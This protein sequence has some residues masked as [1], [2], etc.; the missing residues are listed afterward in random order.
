MPGPGPRSGR[1]SHDERAEAGETVLPAGGQWSRAL[2][3]GDDG[4]R[5]AFAHALLARLAATYAPE[6]MVIALCVSPSRRLSWAWTRWLPHTRRPQD[7]PDLPG[8][9]S[10]DELRDSLDAEFSARPDFDPGA[11]PHHGEP[12]VIVIMDGPEFPAGDPLGGTGLRK[13]VVLDFSGTRRRPGRTTLRLDASTDGVRAVWLGRGRAERSALVTDDMAAAL[14]TPYA[15]DAGASPTGPIAELPDA[16][17]AGRRTDENDWPPPLTAAPRLDDLL[18]PLIPTR[19]RGLTTAGPPAGGPLTVPV[20]IV[21]RPFERFPGVLRVDL[22]GDEGHLFIAGGSGSGK[23]TLMITL[24]AALA[25][26]HTADEVQIH[27]LDLRGSLAAPA[28]LPH[29]RT[30]TDESDPERVGRTLAELVVLLD[31][32]RRLFADQGVDGMADYRRRRAD[33]EF[34][35]ERHGDVY[36]FMDDVSADRHELS[37]HVAALDRLATHGLAYG[38]HL[39]VAV[40]RWPE[41]P[42]SIGDQAATLLELRL[43]DP[44]ES[45]SDPRAAGR[46]P[47]RPGRGLASGTHFLT[48]LPRIDGVEDTRDLT[49]AVSELVTAVA[50]RWSEHPGASN[51]PALEGA[52]SAA[53]LPAAPDPLQAMLGLAESEQTP[54]MHDFATDPHLIVVGDEGSGKTNALRLIVRSITASHS[55]VKARFLVMDRRDDLVYAV[56][57]E[58]VLG[59]AV[60]AAVLSELVDGAARAIGERVPDPESR[61]APAPWLGPRLFIVVDDYE[62]VDEMTPSPFEPLFEYLTVG[63]EVGMHLVVARSSA[64]TGTA[65]TDPLLCALHEAGAATLALS[66][67]PAES[68][69]LDDIEPSVL[70]PGRGQY[71]MGGETTLIR[72]AVDD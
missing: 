10:V 61:E 11:P 59:H 28:D 47:R 35:E 55:P 4:P 6:E 49:V 16:L 12:L 36:L 5:R 14:L 7:E 19:D 56:P 9:S 30:V 48:A 25:L 2:F 39:V 45:A 32:R 27:C 43:G 60:S 21:D 58:F 62:Q 51:A 69:V 53:S 23:S 33:G 40:P 18:P 20:G 65:M 22:S 46:V 26:T 37:G 1:A 42:S 38:I 71:R 68:Q 24:I 17:T 15:S 54:I 44:A 29:I 50:E 67:S 3:R 8:V 57:E 41:L 31:H 64:S 34:T 72:I 52:L 70:P 13:T 63:Y 66:T